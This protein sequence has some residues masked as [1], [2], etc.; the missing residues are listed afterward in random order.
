MSKISLK[1]ALIEPIR[2]GADKLIIISG[3]ASHNMASWHMKKINEENLHPIDIELIVGMC[4]SDGLMVDIHEGFKKLVSFPDVKYSSF[5]CKYIFQ[6]P[7]IHSKVYIWLDHGKPVCAYAGSANYTQSG[8]LRAE[9][10]EYVVECDPV[11][12]YEYYQRL[13]DSSIF[14][15]HSEVDDVIRLTNNR[16]VQELEE[17]DV[18][19][20]ETL[21]TVTLSLLTTRN[22]EVGKKSG[23]NWGHR[24]ER[25][26]NPN[27]AYIAQ[28]V[29][30]ARKGF[31]PLNKQ[32]FSVITDDHK[33]LILRTESTNG[34]VITTPLN[35]SLLG[36]YFRNR[37]GVPSGS[38]ITKQNLLDYGRTDVTFYKIDDEQY[39]MDFSV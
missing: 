16:A 33:Q 13:D 37:I 19:L 8:W 28:P 34:K 1:E 9:R 27:E 31:F 6:K 7:S 17:G 39:Y 32:H 25:N 30:I 29:S 18:A 11:A 2:K 10:S 36:E 14:C 26:R 4:P 35:N 38:F 22:D 5:S 24:P 15:N 3:Y 12:A 21:P 20:K 23:L